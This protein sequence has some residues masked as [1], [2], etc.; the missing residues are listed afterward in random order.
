MARSYAARYRIPYADLVQEGY[1]AV[2]RAENTYDGKN[3]CSFGSYARVC[4]KNRFEN[5]RRREWKP[6][7]P[8][9]AETLAELRRQPAETFYA[10]VYDLEK[11]EG[12][13]TGDAARFW[14]RY[15]ELGGRHGS[16]TRIAREENRSK[17]WATKM[18]KAVFVRLRHSLERQQ[19]N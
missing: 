13:L 18:L 3:G 1:L 6:F 14:R 7:T 19:R 2:N 9:E 12:V 10:D 17:Q 11:A 4:L 8:V 5:I 16:L 15:K